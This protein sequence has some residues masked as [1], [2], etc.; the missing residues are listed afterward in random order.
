MEENES[1]QIL[2]GDTGLVGVSGILLFLREYQRAEN[3]RIL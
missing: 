1:Y 2:L 3:K